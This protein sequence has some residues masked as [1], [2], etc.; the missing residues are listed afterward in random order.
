[1]MYLSTCDLSI[2][3]KNGDL[4]SEYYYYPIDGGSEIKCNDEHVDIQSAVSEY[5]NY[6]Q[7]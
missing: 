7:K 5:R 3:K 2:L 6:L 4:Q 1:M